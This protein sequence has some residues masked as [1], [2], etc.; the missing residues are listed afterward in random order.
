MTFPEPAET[1]RQPGARPHP[2]HT[3]TRLTRVLQFREC[4]PHGSA[5][6]CA[7]ASRCSRWLRSDIRKLN[8]WLDA[9][10]KALNDR[11]DA[12][13]KALN[14]RLDTRFDAVMHEI[15]DLR[16]RMAKMEGFL[17]GF[18]AGRRDRDAA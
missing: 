7:R 11:L 16:E 13:A 17:D 2:A 6:A 18:L 1:R 15:A 10:T 3:P 9:A 14:D 4:R 8:D 12:T 5:H